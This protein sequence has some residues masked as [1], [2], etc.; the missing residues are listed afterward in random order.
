MG[1]KFFLLLIPSLLSCA[2]IPPTE[3]VD[4]G[5]GRIHRSCIAASPT[6]ILR[7]FHESSQAGLSCLGDLKSEQALE[8]QSWLAGL[9]KKKSITYTCAE[10]SYDW[11]NTRATADIK[12]KIVSISPKFLKSSLER[13]ESAV[14]DYEFKQI[15]FHEN[16]HL[17][18][19][20]HNTTLDYAYACV[21]CCFPNPGD[22][23]KSACKICSTDYL[24]ISDPKYLEDVWAWSRGSGSSEFINHHSILRNALLDKPGSDPH[25]KKILEEDTSNN[26]VVKYLARGLGNRS[27]TA[28]YRNLPVRH[29]AEVLLPLAKAIAKVAADLYVEGKIDS[30][31]QFYMNLDTGFLQ[32]QLDSE[33]TLT[34]IYAYA[35]WEWVKND[36]FVLRQYL[37]DQ[38]L[39]ERA[40]A[41]GRK[42]ESVI[43]FER[44]ENLM[45]ES[46]NFFSN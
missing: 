24:G 14:G 38:K 27:Y 32:E 43:E 39:N 42:Y 9:F 19:Y 41:L 37:W 31:I 7:L 8:H 1:Y 34:K 22:D 6:R 46:L 35:V 44:S 2:R 28:E 26:L 16:M 12:K 4:S 17:L 10:S 3:Y 36:M 5:S 15:L 33:D 21:E 18:G 29:E 25:L 11:F 45:T 23:Q 40:A 13:G 30:A 20:A